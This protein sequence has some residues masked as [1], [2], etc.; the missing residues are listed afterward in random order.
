MNRLRAL[1]VHGAETVGAGVAAADDDDVLALRRDELLVGDRIALA[2]PVLECQ[3]LHGKV[4][5]PELAAGHRQIARPARAA[6][7]DDRVEVPAQVPDGHVDA[8][9]RVGPED[10]AIL[11]HHSKPPVDE[12]LLHLELGNAVAQ[13]AAD[14]VVA[15]EHGHRVAG[16]VQLLGGGET[17]RPRAHHRDAL[18]RAGRG[19]LGT[20]PAFVE[21]ALD[22]RQLDA[23]DRH[24]VVVDPEHARP[25][26]RRRAETSGPLREV[27]RRV[28]AIERLAPVVLVDQV[29]PVRDDVSQRTA[30]VTERNAA[31]HASRGLLRQVVDRVGQVI[32]TPVPEPLGDGTRGRLL[33]L[34]LEEPGD[35]THWAR[36][37]RR[38]SAGAPRRAPAPRPGAPAC[39]RAA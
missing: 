24:R 33:P 5:A 35:F 29:V 20:D 22:D 38:R 3:V 30:L 11:L 7:Q 27:V 9:V 8:D 17:R 32:L 13:Q 15:L 1:A 21:R 34:D 26:A 12:P 4:N 19:R 23:L 39:S 10:D 2:A 6:G 25:L 14:P 31:V 16:A 28:Q 37:A 18:A 36:P